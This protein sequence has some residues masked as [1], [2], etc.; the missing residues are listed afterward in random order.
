[1]QRRSIVSDDSQTEPMPSISG[2]GVQAASQQVAPLSADSAKSLRTSLQQPSQ[3]TVQETGIGLAVPDPPWTC[4]AFFGDTLSG[5]RHGY[6]SDWQLA[7][8]QGQMQHQ[9]AP[10]C[11]I[12]GDLPAAPDRSASSQ[13]PLLETRRP[14]PV[15]NWTRPPPLTPS[16]HPDDPAAWDFARRQRSRPSVLQPVQTEAALSHPSLAVYPSQQSTT[17]S[18]NPWHPRHEAL[19]WPSSANQP[20]F[21][22]WQPRG[23]LPALR[24]AQNRTPD[25]VELVQNAIAAPERQHLAQSWLQ[26]QS[27]AS[28]MAGP[29]TA[30]DLMEMTVSMPQPQTWEPQ[31]QPNQQLQTE[32]R[33]VFASPLP[34][35]KAFV[36]DSPAPREAGPEAISQGVNLQW[37]RLTA[38]LL[39]AS[40]TQPADQHDPPVSPSMD[41]PD[42]DEISSQG[43][44][45]ESEEE[46]IAE[47]K[48]SQQSPS[49]PVTSG[50]IEGP[51]ATTGLRRVSSDSV[52]DCSGIFC[53]NSMQHLQ[54]I[55]QLDADACHADSKGCIHNQNSCPA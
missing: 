29:S 23:A 19:G 46:T 26:Q 4:A 43:H 22:A 11:V 21:Q 48:S 33:G 8:A 39:P 15:T 27:S 50:S 12:S 55:Q 30:D 14:A 54:D 37:D 40:E 32:L 52:L 51:P 3:R 49:R 34:A 45:I 53:A 7:D 20:A 24:P 25:A 17:S 18:A 16:V 38:A 5:I 28:A 47:G 6:S 9:L 10:A 35:Q 44:P 1:M 36:D 41:V 42:P 2:L 31:R 13:T